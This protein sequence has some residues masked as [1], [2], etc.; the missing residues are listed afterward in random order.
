MDRDKREV[1]L[2]E[3]NHWRKGRLLPEQYC[4]FLEN[5]YHDEEI[6]SSRSIFSLGLIQQGNL[7]S[8]FLGFGIISFFF[9]IVFYFSLFPWP[10]QITITLLLSALGYLF[11][12]IHRHRHEL[13]SLALAG[14]GSLILLGL[15][16]LMI[17]LQGWEGETATSIL[18]SVCGIVWFTVGV[19][20][21]FNILLYCGLAFGMLLYA[22]FFGWIHP[23]SLWGMLQLL[24][25]PLSIIFF[26][27]TWLCHYRIK[28]LTRVMFAASL[29]LWFMPEMDGLLLRQQSAQGMEII[30][31]AKI[32][33]AF[34]L[35]YSLR[36]KW[37][38]W[39]SS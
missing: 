6:K 38:V 3:I 37:V 16:S 4:D 14:A 5:L 1:I 29:T 2:A 12:A 22:F 25:L 21:R 18:I 28:R 13:L 32:V 9:F 27:L 31:L 20:M 7:K 36:K 26:W 35:L 23:E 24:W 30:I 17:A 10:L 39:I 8:W 15:G 19:F 33:V 34:V 11:S